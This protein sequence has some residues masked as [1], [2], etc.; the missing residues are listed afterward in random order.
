MKT[1]IKCSLIFVL[2]LFV[3]PIHGDD[4]QDGRDA[5]KRKDYK[6]AIEK[7]NPLAEQGDATAQNNLG[8]MY[9]RG[10][11]VPRDFKN[12]AK[13]LRLSAEQ[14]HATA[15]FN[16]GTMYYHG[17]GVGQDYK[18]AVKL[19]RLAAEQDQAKAQNYLGV[20][21]ATGQGVNKDNVRAHKWYSIAGANGSEKGR[22]NRKIVAEPMTPDQI[23]EAQMLA[24]E[25]MEKHK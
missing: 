23:A 25:W 20:M 19:F 12:A 13:W 2:S 5:Y 22:K 18:E 7:W 1:I 16:L 15:Q 9:N 14:G 11:G 24:R 17:H 21:Y 4:L 6:T 10:R 3:A 8:A